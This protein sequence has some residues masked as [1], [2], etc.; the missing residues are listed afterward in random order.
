MVVAQV[1]T[2]FQNRRMKH[3]KHMRKQASSNESDKALG[4]VG[5]S[6]NVASV[7]KESDDEEDED[8]DDSADEDTRQDEDRMTLEEPKPMKPNRTLKPMPSITIFLES[9]QDSWQWFFLP[10]PTLASLR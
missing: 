3:K 7:E 9:M 5:E 4:G 6:S 8:S 1:K 2:W 10:L